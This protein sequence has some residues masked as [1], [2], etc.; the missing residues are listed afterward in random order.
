MRK[1]RLFLTI[2]VLFVLALGW[3]AILHLVVLRAANASVQHLRRPDLADKAWLSL[4]LTAGL[5]SLF[6]WG[7]TRVARSG[8]VREGL[9][10]GL[11]F[12]LV[13]GLLVDLNQYVL[14]PI[15]GVVAWQWFLGGLFEFCLYGIV[16]SRL[17]PPSA[18]R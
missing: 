10:Y 15:P 6:V 2:G 17:C 4:V 11:F 7:Y 8:S 16:A 9:G 14:F 1:G 18:S 13:A 12:A 5:V 3:N